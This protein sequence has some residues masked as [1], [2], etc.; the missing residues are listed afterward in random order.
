MNKKETVKKYSTESVLHLV[1]GIKEAV[2]GL[3][4]A[5]SI[6]EIKLLKEYFDEIES[7]IKYQGQIQNKRVK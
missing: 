7:E 3:A 5:G 6:N 1:Y 2:I 4:K